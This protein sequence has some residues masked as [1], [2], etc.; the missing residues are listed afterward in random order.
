MTGRGFGYCCGNYNPMYGGPRG[1]GFGR[2]RRWFNDEYPYGIPQTQP[3]IRPYYTKPSTVEERSHLEGLV[4][5]LETELEEIKERI[6]K[7]DR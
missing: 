1:R 2:G 4:K 7:L 3:N 5:E 6:E